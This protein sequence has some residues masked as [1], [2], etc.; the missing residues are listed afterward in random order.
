MWDPIGMSFFTFK[1][2]KDKEGWELKK[3]K[4]LISNCAGVSVMG[5]MKNYYKN[6]ELAK[7]IQGLKP[8]YR[9]KVM[10]QFWKFDLWEGDSAQLYVDRQVKWSQVFGANEGET[11][12]P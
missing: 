10:F 5:G 4:D 8:H 7:I 1:D 2:D 3:G 11:L 12:C 9:I 6:T